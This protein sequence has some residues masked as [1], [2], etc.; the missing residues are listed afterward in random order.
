[1]ISIVKSAYA[2]STTKLG[3][4]KG[5]GVF[6][7][8]T[9]ANIRENLGKFISNLITTITVIGGLAF[10]I[11]FILGSI[12]W[13]TAGGDKGK[14]QEAQTQMT[15]AAIGLIAM[16]AAYSIIGIV[17]GVLGINILNPFKTLF[18]TL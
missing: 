17:G 10:V 1:M 7:D 15:Q 9:S 6:G 3:D 16:T 5:T 2:A 18:P 4:I 13:I 8:I 11:Y 12:K 14:M